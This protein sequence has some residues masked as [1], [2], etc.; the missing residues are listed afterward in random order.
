MA[1]KEKVVNVEKYLSEERKK[2][3]VFKRQPKLLILGSSDSG[4]STLLKQLK[5]M[6][7]KGFTDE[8]KVVFSKAI[9]DNIIQSL[10]ILFSNTE[11]LEK[12]VVKD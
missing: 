4:K 5:I 10:Y 9:K 7:G 2:Y 11:R 1:H 12:D 6:H 8:E 3:M